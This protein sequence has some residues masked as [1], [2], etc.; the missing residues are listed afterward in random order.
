MDRS[1]T[2]TTT[3]NCWPHSRHHRGH[4]HRCGRRCSRSRHSRR[5]GWARAW[6][7]GVAGTSPAPADCGSPRRSSRPGQFPVTRTGINYSINQLPPCCTTQCDWSIANII[8]INNTQQKPVQ[9]HFG[10][11]IQSWSR[12]PN[13]KDMIPSPYSSQKISLL[14][15][16]RERVVRVS[17]IFC[18][19]G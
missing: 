19:D 3:T 12:R 10:L 18:S 13:E 9:L 7:T 14:L 11:A 1:I 4:G 15:A 2:A 6:W 5:L 17:C 8:L 16:Y